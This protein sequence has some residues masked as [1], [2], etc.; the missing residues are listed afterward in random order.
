MSH[1]HPAPF[2]PGRPLRLGMVAAFAVLA[3]HVPAGLAQTPVSEATP[4]VDAA[5]SH[6]AHIHAGT[7][8]E[9]GDVV[10]PLENVED[11]SAGGEAAG[12]DSAHAV[13]ISRTFVD[14][15][16][17]DIIAGGHAINV[18]LS[19]DEIGT[20]IACGDVGGVLTEEGGRT[21][22]IMGL[23]ELNDSGYTGIAWLGSDDDQTEVVVQ[24]I[25]PEELD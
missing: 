4:I 5:A 12:P 21:H 14:I 18:H 25:Q 17:D 24:L 11:I 7:C 20:Y 10:V 9:L 3:M 15:P 19:D 23:G 13:E 8:A 6:P 16:L 1:V 2:T 22:L